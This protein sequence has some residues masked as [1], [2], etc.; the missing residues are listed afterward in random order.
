MK[1]I[2]E[3]A[4][5][6]QKQSERELNNINEQV[7]NAIIQHETNL[8]E[9]LSI[10]SDNFRKSIQIEQQNSIEL[11]KKLFKIPFVVG[12]ILISIFGGVLGLMIWQA[13]QQYSE[14]NQWK[15]SAELWKTQSNGMKLQQCLTNKEEQE[16]K[17]CIAIDPNYKDKMWGAENGEIL[18]IVKVE[19]YQKK[20]NNKEKSSSK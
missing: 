17:L 20:T 12:M 6:F 2:S 18:K 13:E 3:L 19:D 4:T 14:M 16:V 15:A 10:V 1:K 7:Q 5:A 9:Q 8:K 11:T